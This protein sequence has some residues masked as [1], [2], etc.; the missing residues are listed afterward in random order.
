MT[1]LSSLYIE[2]LDDHRIKDV[3]DSYFKPID[4][5]LL[6]GNDNMRVFISAI[7]HL[8]IDDMIL[9]GYKG[10]CQN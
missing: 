7:D 2:L 6:E 3:K 8:A 4:V 10:R 5:D 9:T 1:G